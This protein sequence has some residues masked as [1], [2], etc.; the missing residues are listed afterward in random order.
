[1]SK[2]ATVLLVGAVLLGCSLDA[3]RPVQAVLPPH[4]TTFAAVERKMPEG[5]LDDAAKV[6]AVR[7][8]MR[9]EPSGCICEIDGKP[10]GLMPE[11]AQL[12]GERIRHTNSARPVEL[13]VGPD[14][15]LKH[16]AIVMDQLIRV[17][18]HRINVGQ[19]PEGWDFRLLI[20][21]DAPWTGAAWI[22]QVKLAHVRWPADARERLIY[23]DLPRA[24]MAGSYLADWWGIHD[25]T[26]TIAR[27]RDAQAAKFWVKHTSMTVEELKAY[28]YPLFHAKRSPQVPVLIRC[29]KEVPFRFLERVMAMCFDEDVLISKVVLAVDDEA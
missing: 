6:K 9:M 1:M 5:F 4:D 15:P 14:V 17:K 16:V 23:V 10:V 12:A 25:F 22:A 3:E 19:A 7:V 13:D 21:A 8:K 2:V 18:L 26:V 20:A 27:D 29:D 28:F 11:S 24:E